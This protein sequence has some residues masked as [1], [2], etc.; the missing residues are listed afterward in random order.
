MKI[1]KIIL[2]PQYFIIINLIYGTF[3]FMFDYKEFLYRKY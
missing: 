3:N 1:E 2:L